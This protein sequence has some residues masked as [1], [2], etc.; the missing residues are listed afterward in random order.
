MF[1]CLCALTD[2]HELNQKIKEEVSLGL[3]ELNQ[4]KKK[5]HEN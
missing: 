3:C 2:N 5:S 4:F 1:Y